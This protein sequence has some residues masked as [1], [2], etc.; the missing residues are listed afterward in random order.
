MLTSEASPDRSHSLIGV[1]P[2]Q[3]LPGFTFR[4][5]HRR[6]TSLTSGRALLFIAKRRRFIPTDPR[7]FGIHSITTVTIDGLVVLKDEQCVFRELTLPASAKAE[8][9]G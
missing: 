9:K 5:D 2:F 8:L 3:V 7:S 4:T 1:D 6:E